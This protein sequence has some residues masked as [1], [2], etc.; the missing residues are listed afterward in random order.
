MSVPTCEEPPTH[1]SLILGS[2]STMSFTWGGPPEPQS[3]RALKHRRWE[4]P[5][6]GL[7]GSSGNM[8]ATKQQ[9]AVVVVGFD[10]WVSA[11]AHNEAPG[12]GTRLSERELLADHHGLMAATADVADASPPPADQQQLS[13]SQ[14]R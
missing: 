9:G 11:P 3:F 7:N 10:H 13:L 6:H 14:R 5:E 1:Q 12:P 8:A 2:H 4:E